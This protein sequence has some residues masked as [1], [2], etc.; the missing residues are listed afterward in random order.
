MVGV[1]IWAMAC[2]A[3]SRTDL[4]QIAGFFHVEHGAVGGQTGLN[5]RNRGAKLLPSA[6]PP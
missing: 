2:A 3:E 1:I 4:D 6:V 5:G